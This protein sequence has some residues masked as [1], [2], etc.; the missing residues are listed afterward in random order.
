MSND[1]LGSLGHLAL[2][3]R[4]KRAG[5]LLQAATQAWLRDAGCDVPAAH[6]PLLAAL[7]SVGSA[8]LGTLVDLLGVA[9]PGVSRMVDSLEADGWITTLSETADKRVRVLE[10]TGNGRE[11]VAAAKRSLWPVVQAAVVDLCADL[12]GPLT[13][14]LAGLE[15]KLS[16]GAY[17]DALRSHARHR[18]RKRDAA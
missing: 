7:D 13:D 8:S 2:G 5:T 10:L 17:D 14:Q 1:F 9:Q 11:L 3:S 18:R 12:S 16:A 6:M 15:A 4:L